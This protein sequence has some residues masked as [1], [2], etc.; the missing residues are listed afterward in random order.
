[1]NVLMLNNLDI[2][3]TLSTMR[4]QMHVRPITMGLNLKMTCHQPYETCV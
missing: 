3:D 1:M 2:L 4:Q